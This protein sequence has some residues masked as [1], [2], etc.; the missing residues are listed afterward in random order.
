MIVSWTGHSFSGIVQPGKCCF[1]ERNGQRTYLDSSFEIDGDR[2]VS[3]DRGC[4]PD[5]DER[6]WGS[7]AGPFHFVRW[8]NFA[9]EV[10]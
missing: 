5:T 3:L 8:A 1:V 7:V 4:D 10:R 6:V 9:D 2:F